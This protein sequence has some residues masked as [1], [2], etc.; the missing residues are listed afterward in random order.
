[1][2]TTTQSKQSQPAFDAA[3]EQIK[4]FNEQFV[5]TA[6]KVGVQYLDTYEKAVDRA[7]DLELKV[8]GA[9][10]QEWLKS[11]IDGQVD[12]TRE[13]TDAYTKAARGLLK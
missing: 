10:K 11:L 4:E 7:I 9:T 1:M 12:M 5:E 13:L 3:F 8:A 2:A 6:R